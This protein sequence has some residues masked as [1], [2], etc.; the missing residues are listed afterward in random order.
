MSCWIIEQRQSE[1]ENDAESFPF[2]INILRNVLPRK[3]RM[4]LAH[5]R[6]SPTSFGRGLTR[7]VGIPNKQKHKSRSLH[8]FFSGCTLTGFSNPEISENTFY[9]PSIGPLFA[10]PEEKHPRRR[11]PCMCASGTL[12]TKDFARD[13]ECGERAGGERLFYRKVSCRRGTGGK[14]N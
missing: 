3:L 12:K 7:F 13:F 2:W 8:M 10:T 1:R 11:A 14:R 4:L 6:S 9:L 5:P